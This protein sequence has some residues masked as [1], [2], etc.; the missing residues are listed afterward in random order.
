MPTGLLPHALDQDFL[1]PHRL[2]EGLLSDHLVNS[3]SHTVDALDP[4]A[5]FIRHSSGA[6]RNQPSTPAMMVKVLVDGCATGVFS[7]RKI[8][9]KLHE[10]LPSRRQKSNAPLARRCPK[11]KTTSPIPAAASRRPGGSAALSR[12]EIDLPRRLLGAY[13]MS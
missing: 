3:I 8:A 12:A 4:R 2:P 13:R 11:R 6:A 10:P 9:S 7:S 1:L 5:F